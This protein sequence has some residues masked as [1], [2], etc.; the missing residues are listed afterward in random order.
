[1]KLF[2]SVQLSFAHEFIA[3]HCSVSSM[4]LL[5]R[6]SSVFVKILS[7]ERT[8]RCKGIELKS[9]IGIW[10][11]TGKKNGI[12]S[13]NFNIRIS[14]NYSKKS[15]FSTCITRWYMSFFFCLSLS[16]VCCLHR[17]LSKQTAMQSLLERPTRTKRKW[18]RS[19]WKSRLEEAAEQKLYF[20]MALQKRSFS[21]LSC[22]KIGSVLYFYS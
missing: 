5:I 7:M 20:E 8:W 19:R 16:P 21:E 4:T 22:R 10:T 3:L 18:E 2:S 11:R 9:E 13:T 17:F 14:V 15:P 1:M 6:I 12:I